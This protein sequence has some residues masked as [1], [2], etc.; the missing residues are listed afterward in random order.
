MTP[1]KSANICLSVVILTDTCVCIGSSPLSASALCH[2]A[3]SQV[4]VQSYSAA[5]TQLRHPAAADPVVAAG[6]LAQLSRYSA[7]Q[8]HSDGKPAEPTRCADGSGK[9]PDVL[10]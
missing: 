5:A 8:L 3:L 9:E 4:P 6:A 10:R 1:A 2:A 7:A